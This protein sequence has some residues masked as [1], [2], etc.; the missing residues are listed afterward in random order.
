MFFFSSP[1]NLF[2]QIIQTMPF[3]PHTAQVVNNMIFPLDV[4]EGQ[5]GPEADLRCLKINKKILIVPLSG[6]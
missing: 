4:V 5:S 3:E 1:R 2:L 6:V